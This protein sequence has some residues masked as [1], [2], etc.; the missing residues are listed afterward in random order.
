MGSLLVVALLVML[1]NVLKSSVMTVTGSA[2][3]VSAALVSLFSLL[4]LALFATLIIP[5]V[6]RNGIQPV[7]DKTLTSCSAGDVTGVS[8]IVEEITTFSLRLIVALSALRML[9]ATFSAVF[10]NAIDGSV[11][12]SHALIESAEVVGGILLL[13]LISPLIVK[14]FGSC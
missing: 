8:S 14:F 4:I 5:E 9:K 10:Y 13:L 2:S 1:A 12:L 11:G 6:V 3:G 7:V